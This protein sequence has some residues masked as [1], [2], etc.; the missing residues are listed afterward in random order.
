MATVIPQFSFVGGFC[1]VNTNEWLKKNMYNAW[2]L[3]IVP[4]LETKPECRISL[5]R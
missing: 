4:L 1:D 2:R 3:V 5:I